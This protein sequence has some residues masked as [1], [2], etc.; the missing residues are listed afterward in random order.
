[1]PTP[2]LP[3]GPSAPRFI[4]TAIALL[5]RQQAMRRM[6]DR[7][8]S[9]FTIDV[10]VYGKS[11][12]LSDPGEIRQLFTTSPEIVDNAD[13]IL[14][15]FLGPGSF[16]ALAGE[17]HRRQ[18]KLLVPPFHGPRLKTYEKIIE[19]EAVREMASWRDGREF[20]T[21]ESMLR[22][23]LNA[24]LRAVFGAD[25]GD[26]RTLRELLPGLVALGSRLALLP[27]PRITL[28]PFSP[29][30]RFARYRRAYDAAVDRLID[31]AVHHTELDRRDDVL[32][33]MLRSRYENGAGMSRGEIADQLLTLLAAGH[34]TTATTL[35]WAVERLR[36]HPPMLRRLAEE[37]DAGGSQLRQATIMEVQRVRPVIDFVPRKVLAPSMRVGR[38]TLTRGQYVLVSISLIHNDDSVFPDAGSFDPD[39][40]TDGKADVYKW[41][42]FGGG[43]RR[44]IGAAFAQMEMDVVLRTLLRDYAIM[45]TQQPGERVSSRGV[46]N[47]PDK[48]G[49]VVVRR[50]TPRHHDIAGRGCGR[51]GPT[52][53]DLNE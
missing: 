27:L 15:P 31:R 43:A 19:E 46:A 4:Q 9:A 13:N 39:R 37:C 52:G 18:R 45:P 53:R 28:G 44:C 20:A 12:V 14:A 23:T 17:A 11:L 48:G 30:E 36:R 3:D 29:W 32:A 35:A 6:R 34:E 42:P 8:G 26:L 21:L 41:I 40:F 10:A 49:R 24:I 5:A 16:F 2:T 33:L 38:W 51:F 7:Y 47:A 25:G 50:R 1:V 22:I